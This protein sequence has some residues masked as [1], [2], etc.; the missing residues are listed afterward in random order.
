VNIARSRIQTSIDHRLHGT[1]QMDQAANFNAGQNR[2][3][4]ERPD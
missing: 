1:S 2:F 3:F 4:T